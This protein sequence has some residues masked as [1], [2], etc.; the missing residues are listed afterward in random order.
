MKKSHVLFPIW[1]EQ[2]LHGLCLTP[3][4][5]SQAGV[6][7]KGDPA[8]TVTNRKGPTVPILKTQQTVRVVPTG[9]RDLAGGFSHLGAAAVCLPAPCA[10]QAKAFMFPLG[11]DPQK[12][13]SECLIIMGV[14]ARGQG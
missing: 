12:L 13:P 5:R 7:E 14:T 2:L 9:L 6:N 3:K 8:S 10:L 11:N 1:K 4:G